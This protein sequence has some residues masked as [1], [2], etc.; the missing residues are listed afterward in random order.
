M[1]MKL[2]ESSCTYREWLPIAYVDEADDEM[3]DDPDSE[4][5]CCSNCCNLVDP[6]NVSKYYTPDVVSSYRRYFLNLPPGD[7]DSFI[8]ERRYVPDGRTKRHAYFV[9]AP[10]RMRTVLNELATTD[11]GY[12]GRL[13]SPATFKKKFVCGNFL[14]FL[15]GLSYEEKFVSVRDADKGVHIHGREHKKGRPAVEWLQREKDLHMILPDTDLTVLPYSDLKETHAAFVEE[16]ESLHE[17]SW[18]E[19]AARVERP[20]DDDCTPDDYRDLNMGAP[21]QGKSSYRYGNPLLGL[22]KSFPE[23]EDICGLTHFCK[24]WRQDPVAGKAVCR[25]HIPFAKCDACC[26]HRDKMKDTTDIKEKIKLQEEHRVHIREVNAERGVYWAHRAWSRERPE[27]HL[28]IIVDGADNKANNLPHA[29]EMSHVA[30]EAWK[31]KMH[32]MGVIV[33]GRDTNLFTMPSHVKCGH[34]VTIQ[35]IWDTITRILKAEGKLPRTLYVQLDNTSRQNKGRY[36]A[37]FLEVLVAAGLFERAYMCF[38]PV[39]HTH[40]DIDQ[41]FSR[42]SIRLRKND[43][44]DRKHLAWQIR[45]SYTTREGRKPVVVHWD[46]LA[47]I[48]GWLHKHCEAV[49]GVTEFRHF[50]F[51]RDVRVGGGRAI[52]QCK[53]HMARRADESWGGIGATDTYDVVMKVKAEEFFEALKQ[54]T[55]PPAQ[56]NDYCEESSRKRRKGITEI[57]AKYPSFKDEAQADCELLILMDEVPGEIEFNWLHDDITAME[58][59]GL[60]QLK[61]AML[62][63]AGKVADG[64]H[65]INPDKLLQPHAAAEHKENQEAHLDVEGDV[66]V[67][68]EVEGEGE[69]K[70]NWAVSEMLPGASPGLASEDSWHLDVEERR[71]GQAE[72]VVKID[73]VWMVA[74]AECEDGF[75][76]WL[77]KIKT[78]AVGSSAEGGGAIVQYLVPEKFQ[79]VSKDQRDVPYLLKAKYLP[80]RL[81]RKDPVQHDFLPFGNRATSPWQARVK[82]IENKKSGSVTITSKGKKTIEAWLNRASD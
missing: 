57:A 12:K 30:E 61:T 34:N 78:W 22:R 2:Q 24:L 5:T 42:I 11:G 50:R 69:D 77:A 81:W 72:P 38:L 40:E 58:E 59:Y 4:L 16:M 7:R 47:N 37:A 56:R 71:K 44:W 32:L 70:V 64:D 36:L 26:S 18:A 15:V 80:N 9:E 68:G 66:D 27:D 51:K 14:R 31:T 13:P 29:A 76:F 19:G 28:S 63:E 82:V 10:R 25:A 20:W 43:A 75:S 54:R 62:V 67:E 52:M 74:P 53:H 60:K 21:R 8:K 45:Q 65:S 23:H 6:D 3:E 79:N 49:D 1:H 17:C 41:L 48:S 55:I 73:D 35:A 46:T 33:H 39:G